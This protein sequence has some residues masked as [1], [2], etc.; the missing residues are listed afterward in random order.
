MN[1][2]LLRLV[3]QR[4]QATAYER[5]MSR[6][7]LNSCNHEMR[8]CLLAAISYVQLNTHLPKA[9]SKPPSYQPSAMHS[10]R[11]APHTMILVIHDYAIS[12]VSLAQYS[13]LCCEFAVLVLV[14]FAEAAAWTIALKICKMIIIA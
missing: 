4:R 6:M 7:A 9:R 11:L 14:G 1:D 5:P 12:V 10:L 3:S 13:T 8:N 2:V